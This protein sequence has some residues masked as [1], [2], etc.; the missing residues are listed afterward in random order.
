MTTTNNGRPLPWHD[1]PTCDAPSTTWVDGKAVPDGACGGPMVP[2]AKMVNGHG[3]PAGT[4]IACVACGH[5]RVGTAAEV[6]QATRADRAWEMHEAGLIH[7]DRGC[8]RCNG[9]LPLDR[10]RLCGPCVVQDNN[11][12]QGVLL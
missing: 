9:P 2:V 7:I 8:A 1:T 6:A 10:E 5:G 11:D 12:R 3:G 4:R